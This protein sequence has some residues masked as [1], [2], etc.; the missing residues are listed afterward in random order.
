MIRCLCFSG[1]DYIE[2]L[3]E[4]SASLSHKVNHNFLICKI[5]SENIY[6]KILEN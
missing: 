3:K 6:F 2:W 5:Y 4:D 1:D